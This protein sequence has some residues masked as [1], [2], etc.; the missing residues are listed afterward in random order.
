MR[1]GPYANRE[2]LQVAQQRLR[3]NDIDV[4]VLREKDSG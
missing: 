2:A 4:L 3:D 1:V